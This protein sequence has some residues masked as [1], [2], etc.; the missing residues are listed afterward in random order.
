MMISMNRKQLMLRKGFDC[1][2]EDTPTIELSEAQWSA[3]HAQLVN[4]ALAASEESP[5]GSS[6]HVAEKEEPYEGS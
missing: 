4:I 5:A 1:V 2:D 6:L 3:I